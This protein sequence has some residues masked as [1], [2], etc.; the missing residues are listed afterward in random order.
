M[1]EVIIL[2]EGRSYLRRKG[3]DGLGHEVES[4]EGE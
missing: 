2:A 1:Y 4:D 3:V